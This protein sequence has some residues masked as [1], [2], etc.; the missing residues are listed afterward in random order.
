MLKAISK[1]SKILDVCNFVI[2]YSE[3]LKQCKI[4][5]NEYIVQDGLK[6]LNRKIE[7][8]NENMAPFAIDDDY[9][10]TVENILEYVLT[11]DEYTGYVPYEEPEKEAE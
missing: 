11:L 9:N 10:Q 2:N 4:Y 8:R 3:Q 6:T 1:G 7:I 5:L